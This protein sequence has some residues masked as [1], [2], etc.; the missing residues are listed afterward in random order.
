MS[1]PLEGEITRLVQRWQ[2]GDENALERL[3]SHAYDD[4]RAIA[5]RRLD[6]SDPRASLNTTAL[7]HEAYLRLAGVEEK[8]WASRG[9][10]FAFCS[11]AMRHIL[12][13]YARARQTAKRGGDRERVPLSGELGAMDADI[14]RV[15]AVEEALV[16][17]EARD[18]RLARMVECRFFGG[19]TT[20]ETAEAL[21]VTPRTVAR[22]WVRAQAHLRRI[23]G[24][25]VD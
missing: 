9:H 14:D 18:E 19:L 4:L 1:E 7:V 21:G 6:G 5:H 22:D 12:I 25:G 10:F 2:E 23:L 16:V 11:K 15:L 20:A 8:A 17:L 3:V 13:D 24:T